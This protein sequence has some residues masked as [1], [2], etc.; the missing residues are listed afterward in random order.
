MIVPQGRPLCDALIALDAWSLQELVSKRAAV[1]KNVPRVVKGPFRNALQFALEEATATERCRQERRWKL[2]LLLLRMLL[3]RPSRGGLISKEK[4]GARFQLFA[5]CQWAELLA[6]SAT[7]DEQAAVGRRRRRRANGDDLE[8]RAKR[9]EL[10]VGMGEL[11][12]ARQALEGAE[13]APGTNE[14][15]QMLSDHSKRPPEIW[16][17]LPVEVTNHVPEV[18][19]ELSEKIFLKKLRTVKRGAAAGPSGMTLEHLRVLFDSRR[20]QNLFFK[21]AERLARAD[22]PDA[23][24]SVMR[25]GRMTALRLPMAEFVASLQGT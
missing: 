10:L 8:R 4:L 2:F 12:Y 18:P 20:C 9:A 3:H 16:E 5:H 13:L 1:M 14:T 19:F 25:M 17:P 22:V 7:C 24:I 21:L 11:S 6:A 23:I 15:L